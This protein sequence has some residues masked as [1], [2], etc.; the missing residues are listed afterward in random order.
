MVVRARAAASSTLCHLI[1]DVD[2]AVIA[3][4]QTRIWLPCLYEGKLNWHY[5][6]ANDEMQDKIA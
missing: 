2:M 6:H 4:A 3:R 1:D 5:N